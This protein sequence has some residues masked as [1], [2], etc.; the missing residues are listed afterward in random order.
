MFTKYGSIENSYRNKFVS[1]IKIQGFGKSEYIVQEKAHGSN[2][3]YITTDGINFVSAKRNSLI[4]ENDFF[5]NHRKI[6]EQLT[7]KFSNIWNELKSVYPSLEQLTI[8][9]E[10]IGGSYPHPDVA[11]DNT[12]SKVQKGVFYCPT[13]EFY[14]FDILING[15]RY[16]DVDEANFLFEGED[17][18]HAKTLFRGSLADCLDYSN[19]FDSLIPVLLDLPQM[20]PN[21]CEGTVIR[22]VKTRYLAD[23]KR[24]I[25]K[26][27]NEK[28]SERKRSVTTADPAPVSGKVALLKEAISTYVTENRLDNVLSQLGDVT[29]DDR[30]K[31]IGLFSKDTI[32]DFTKDY[33]TQI[34]ELDKAEFKSVRKSIGMKVQ[35]LV[36]ARLMN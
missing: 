2:L 9:G 10:I 4:D 5:H 25:I 23:G 7:P 28:W 31:I 6:R 34:L 15:D 35:E 17:I 32:D 8:F 33:E 16:L 27:K 29:P 11:G 24:I 12:A 22:P 36:W 18:L 3:S 21:I 30:G 20:S 13:N 26:N 14:A 1:K 19:A